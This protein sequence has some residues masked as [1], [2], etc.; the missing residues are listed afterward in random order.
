VVSGIVAWVLFAD[1]VADLSAEG[2]LAARALG[3][4]LVLA[5]IVWVLYLAVEP[6]VRRLWPHALISWAR[7]LAGHVNDARV[8]GDVLIGIATGA[9]MALCLAM[10]HRLLALTA[11]PALPPSWYGLDA[12]L[13]TRE[14]A[15]A[16]ILGEVNAAALGMFLLLMLLLLR[17]VMPEWL[18]I[19]LVVLVPSI[20]DALAS[21]LSLA[22]AIPL[23]AASLAVPTLMLLRF[24]LLAAIANIYVVNV[25]VSLPLTPDV[26]GW[27]GGPTVV[28]VLV[29]G[30]LLVF[31]FHA[32]TATRRGLIAGATS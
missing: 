21:D 17:L 13:G 29:L 7:L 9:G 30:A 24:G 26:G 1:H 16:M 5:L 23:I 32:A 8:G 15:A 4:V 22:V 11:Q 12:L 18:A 19:V 31:G 10:M 14:V 27:R 28:V 2:T 3:A 25:L 6:Y 20:P